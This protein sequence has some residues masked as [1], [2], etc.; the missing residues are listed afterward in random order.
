M[1]QFYLLIILVFVSGFCVAAETY[2]VS[3]KITDTKKQAIPFATV[4]IA[5]TSVGTSTDMNGEFTLNNISKGKVQLLINSMGYE[6]VSIDVQLNNSLHVIA[7][8]VLKE[9]NHNLNEV[10]VKGESKAAQIERSGFAVSSVDTKQLQSKNLEI[11]EVLDQTPGLRVRRDGGLGSETSYNINGL[12][13][14]AVRI[15]IDGVPMESFGSSYSINSI[16]LSLIERIDVYKGVVPVEFGNDAMG[17]AINVV[18]KQMPSMQ[19]KNYTLDASYSVGSFN[20]HRADVAGTWRD[21]KTGLTTRMSAFYNYSD[22]NY[23]VWSDDIKIKDYRE[24]L[25]D[26]SR[27]PDYL[28]VIKTG[29]KV[30]RF[31]DAYESYGIKADVGVTDKKWADQLFF[32]I[33]ASEDYKEIQ[34]GPRMITPY[35][36]RYSTGWTVAPS[37][38]Y[39]K[40]D[41]FTEGLNLTGNFQYVKSQRALTDTTSNKYD[42]YG[43]LIPPVG[44]VTPLP[45]ESGTATLNVDNN[46]NYIGR[47]SAFYSLSENHSLALSYSYNQFVRSSDDEMAEAEQRNFGSTNN[48]NKQITGFTYQNTLFEDKM[49]NSVFVKH[50]HNY[51]QQDKVEMNDNVLDTIH[52]SRADNN[53]GYGATTSYDVSDRVRVS[54]SFEKAIRLVGTN[55]VFGNAAR[56]IVESTDLQPEKSYNF[57]LGGDFTLY[58]NTYSSV[59]LNTNLFYRNTIDRIRRNVV[60]QSGDSYSVYENLGHVT[61]KGIE[62]QLDYRIKQKWHFMVQGYYLDSRFMEKYADNGSENLHYL[63]REPNVPWLTFSAGAGYTK[64][65]LFKNGDRLSINWYS[66]YVH[67]FHFDW[68]VIGDQN[69][70]IVPSQFINDVS[71]G[72]TFAD[73]KMTISLDGKNIFNTMAFDNFAIQKPGRAFYLKLSYRIF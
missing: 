17:G 56:E 31:N 50:Y 15:F 16:P 65:D 47:L 14:S 42:W 18:T 12:S 72:Y 4:V 28:A 59:N 30:Q 34:H 21:K 19:Q 29:E 22:N 33:N 3:G 52:F 49:R 1:K 62:M 37:V 51:L 46:D 7:N 27:N 68:D 41:V 48:V 26:G 11:N 67:E 66:S 39:S 60:V 24:F 54:A 64:S 13:G 69:K 20:T 35:G 44:G 70:P 45:G 53:W 57:N 58:D 61:S 8:A 36:E 25:P 71:V 23:S 9:S 38:S 6:Q 5:N 10:F 32:S 73:R 43:N 63:S 2:T 55:E 40:K